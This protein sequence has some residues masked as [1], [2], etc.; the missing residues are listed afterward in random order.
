[1]VET[2]CLA[3]F[4]FLSNEDAFVNH[5]DTVD[6]LFRLCTRCVQT[7]PAAFLNSSVADN[8]IKC[9]IAASS[10][11]HREANTSVVTFLRD[12]IHG[13]NDKYTG[14]DTENLRKLIIQAMSKHGQDITVGL[15]HAC[16]GK[17]PSYMVPNIGEVLW[18]ML[19]YNKQQASDWFIKAL[20]ILPTQSISGTTVVTK[21]QLMEFHHTITSADACKVV[22]RAAR[23]FSRF[24]E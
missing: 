8:V 10:L 6:D 13:P 24:Y 17:I 19:C 1:M 4:A 2:L 9:A 18:E 16:A 7:S 22:A 20:E 5:P 15:I 14:T 21:Q 11:S 3:T 23:T 12:L